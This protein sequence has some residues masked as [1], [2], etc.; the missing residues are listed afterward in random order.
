MTFGFGYRLTP[1]V[2]RLI[3]ANAV[4]FVVMLVG[5][6]TGWLVSGNVY[7]Y[8]GFTPAEAYMKPWTFVTYMFLHDTRGFLHVLLNMLMLF[9]FGPPLEARWGG[10]EFIKYYLICGI[11]GA[12]FS[13]ATLL[14]LGGANVP[15]VGASGA[16]FGV[17]LAYALNWPDALIWIQVRNIGNQA[18]EPP[19]STKDLPDCYFIDFNISIFLHKFACPESLFFDLV[20]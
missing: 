12:V 9:F 20:A 1:W 7:R 17:M 19:H 13:L 15:I 4:I 10:R 2:K 5:E 14:G 18:F 8:L 11:A 3:I 6:K 16:I